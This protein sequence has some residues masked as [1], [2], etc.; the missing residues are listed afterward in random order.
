MGEKLNG[1][2]DVGWAV[3][4][5]TNMQ[6][7]FAPERTPLGELVYQCKYKGK[8]QLA[9]EIAKQIITR[10]PSVVRFDY[11]I[12]A[13]PS[14]S[15]RQ[16]QPV[17]LIVDELSRITGVPVLHDLFAVSPHAQIKSVSATER[18]DILR[19]N[20]SLA[21]KPKIKTKK[22]LLFDDIYET[23]STLTV[24]CE[25]LRP[26]APIKICVLTAT[27]TKTRSHQ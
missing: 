26:L 12:P 25:L 27:K 21:Q 5:H 13:P 18:L 17:F 9:P 2:W 10:V 14:N 4:L 19:Q 24:L 22:V 20:I 23:G 11:L 16:F 1:V 7:Q 8:R 6:P 3:D 15:A